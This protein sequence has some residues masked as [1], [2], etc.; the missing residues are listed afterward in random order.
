MNNFNRSFNVRLLSLGLIII[1]IVSLTVR[2]RASSTADTATFLPVVANDP[3]RFEFYPVG[4]GFQSVTDITHAGDD[5]LFIVERAGVI[6]ILHPNGQISTFLDI[7]HKVI[8]TRTDKPGQ[9]WGEYGLYAIAFHPNYNVPGQPGYRQFFVTYTSG[10]DDGTPDGLEVDFILARYQVSGDPNVADP[11]SETVLIRENQRSDVHKGGGMEFDPRDHKLYVGMGEDRNGEDAQSDTSKKGKILRLNVDT[12]PIGVE[13]WARGFRNPWRID[14]DWQAN[15]ILVGDVGEITWE[16]VN[17]VPMVWNGAPFNNYGWSCY[18][19]WTLNPD[20]FHSQYCVNST[21]SDFVFPIYGY[22]HTGGRCAIIGGK[23]NRPF[24]RPND[25]RYIYADMCTREV[26]ALTQ[27]PGN[28][29]S[30]LLGTFNG[31]GAIATIGEDRL[32]RQY[33]GSTDMASP[34]YMMIIP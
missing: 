29:Q 20:Y 22:Q 34:V 3:P 30:S 9:F 1:A 23:I 13:I 24:D 14:V 16:E 19:G 33:I 2:T 32:G 15:R 25:G 4:S 21:V 8:T 5:R 12:T 7:R 10:T 17:I 27:A 18:E 6:K 31:M 11:A 28:W 26:F